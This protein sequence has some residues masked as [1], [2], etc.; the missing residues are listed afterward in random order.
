MVYLLKWTFLTKNKSFVMNRDRFLSM[1]FQKVLEIYLNNL[2]GLNMSIY[3]D[4]QIL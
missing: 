3:M 1:I 4:I 2:K